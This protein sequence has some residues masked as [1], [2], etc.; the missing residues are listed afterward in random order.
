MKVGGQRRL[1]IPP[2][3]GYGSTAN[4]PI[5]ANSTLVFDVDLLDVQ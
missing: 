3:L 5:P 2:S 4:G 1:L